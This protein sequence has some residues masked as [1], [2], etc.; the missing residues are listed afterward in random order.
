MTL[1]AAAVLVHDRMEE[2]AGSS[3]PEKTISQEAGVELVS[4]NLCMVFS[5]EPPAAVKVIAYR[6]DAEE[7][8]NMLLCSRGMSS[9]M[10]EGTTGPYMGGLGTSPRMS[11]VSFRSSPRC[12]SPC[13]EHASQLLCVSNSQAL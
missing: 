5:A 10:L 4:D 3:L 6:K 1:P 13:H 8:M 11:A 12:I 9:T 7:S 2:W